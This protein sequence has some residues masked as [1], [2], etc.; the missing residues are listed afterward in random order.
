MLPE[1]LAPSRSAL[2]KEHAKPNRS[3]RVKKPVSFALQSQ[4]TA[5]IKVSK[6]LE[7]QGDN[8]NVYTTSCAHEHFRLDPVSVGPGS[9]VLCQFAVREVIS[10]FPLL[11][12]KLS[13]NVAYVMQ[14]LVVS[15]PR[16]LY[17]NGHTLLFCGT[18]PLVSQSNQ[19]IPSKLSSIRPGLSNHFNILQASSGGHRLACFD[20]ASCED[21]L[22]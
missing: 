5:T 1:H 4:A 15:S 10:S 11:K 22:A 19:P 14:Q 16:S 6:L 9:V 12:L 7:G 13:Q 17:P 2:A 20:E 18:F 3:M 21:R 8:A